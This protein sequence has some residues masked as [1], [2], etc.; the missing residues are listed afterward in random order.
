MTPEPDLMW[1]DLPGIMV[2]DAAAFG[3]NGAASELSSPFPGGERWPARERTGRGSSAD[4]LLLAPWL[5]CPC[6]TVPAHQA[7]LSVPSII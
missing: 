1:L 6:R 3:P 5:V 2:F 4:A 7:F